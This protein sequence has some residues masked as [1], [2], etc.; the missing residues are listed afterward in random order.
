MKKDKKFG[1]L[2]WKYIWYTSL[3]DFFSFIR[4]GIF[5]SQHFVSEC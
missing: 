1:I 5:D 4:L 3:E 2:L